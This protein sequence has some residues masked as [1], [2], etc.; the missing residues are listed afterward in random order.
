MDKI[1]HR[2]GWADCIIQQLPY[3]RFFE[4]VDAIENAE[5]EKTKYDMFHT[6]QLVSLQIE[7]PIGF[8]EYYSNFFKEKND[9]GKKEKNKKQAQEIMEDIE[10]LLKNKKNK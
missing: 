3:A 2:Y 8:D 7:K 9:P 4:I 1:Q 6:W 5:K 10:N